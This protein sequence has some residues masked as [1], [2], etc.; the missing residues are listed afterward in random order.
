MA[1]PLLSA[2]TQTCPSTLCLDCATSNGGTPQITASVTFLPLLHDTCTFD[3]LVYT[4]T[5]SAVP[6]EW[7]VLLPAPPGPC[8]GDAWLWCLMCHTLNRPFGRV[9]PV[10]VLAATHFWRK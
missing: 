5:D 8:S 3:L 1:T 6:V 4:D 7:C 10:S 2:C 9:G